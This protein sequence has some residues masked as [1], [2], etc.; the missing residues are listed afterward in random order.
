[1]TV[2]NTAAPTISGTAQQ[3]LTLATTNGSWTYDLD[4]LTY[5]Y[6]W[7]RC[8]AGGAS[9]VPI[10]GAV[11]PQY[12]IVGADVGSTLRSEVTATEHATPSPETPIFTADFESGTFAGEVYARQDKSLESQ[13]GG[14]LNLT[15]N[16]ST[17]R[18]RIVT[19]GL[20]GSTYAA[21]ILCGPGDTNV[22]GSGSSY[23]TELQI[24]T[25]ISNT[26]YGGASLE[27]KDTWITQDLVYDPNYQF[28]SPATTWIVNTQFWTTGLETGSPC[29]AIESG[30]GQGLSIVIRGG[31]AAS[32]NMRRYT[33][34]NAVPLNT[35][36]QFKIHHHW[37]T[38]SAGVVE[39]WLNGTK[40]VNDTGKPNLAIGSEGVPQHKV[41]TYRSGSSPPSV[42]SYVLVDN[43][44]YYTADPD[45]A[46]PPGVTAPNF[47]GDW[48]AATTAGL[49]T[50]P[51]AADYT[52]VLDGTP[53]S[54][55]QLVTSPLRRTGTTFA[56]KV[57]V[58]SGAPRAE[59]S[60]T[61]VLYTPGMEFWAAWSIYLDPSWTP[62]VSFAL[63]HQFFGETGGQSTGSPPFALE[64]TTS[65]NF[66]LR[67]RGGSKA[68]AGASAPKDV[69]HTI[70]A[71]ST[72]VW[73]DFLAHIRLA[74]DSTGLV[75]VY[76]RIMGGSF[77]GSP[78]ATDTGVNVLTV[79][80]IDQNVYP[81]SGYY[82]ASDPNQIILYTAGMWIR[83]TR[84]AAEA[85]FA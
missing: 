85:F 59:N 20:E 10:S 67:V 65:S 12:L 61:H 75:E 15:A 60:A 35:L 55:M 30:S 66:E 80:G 68:S 78:S 23:R 2:V 33:I 57:T 14:Y 48:H 45:P 73:H 18:T 29:F 77:P 26:F 36:L 8:D 47:S 39:V 6:Q 7:L 82:R 40:V 63:F 72:G 83:S 21:K 19:P 51:Q 1:V 79:A 43:I 50:Q 62:P 3:G 25:S 53:D 11:N 13:P 32:S 81:E 27:G 56:V 41:G 5:A 71:V 54:R 49:L 42:D 38:T 9:C 31:T 58:P 34:A 74:K 64:I 4:Y 46:T 28:G 52:F 70:A 16:L 44:N 17:G 69:G 84:V 76:H 37:S 24:T 22:A